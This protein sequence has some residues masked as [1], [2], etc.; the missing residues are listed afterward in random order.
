MNTIKWI[1]FIIVISFIL[2]ITAF[3]FKS[4]YL[5]NTTPFFIGWF[6]YIFYN[7]YFKDHF[8]NNIK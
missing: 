2:G 7:T 8:K 6:G 3:I 4:T 5:Q 1:A